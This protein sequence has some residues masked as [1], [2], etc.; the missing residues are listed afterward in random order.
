MSKKETTQTPRIRRVTYISCFTIEMTEDGQIYSVD[1][2]ADDENHAI[3][4]A[5]GVFPN[6]HDFKLSNIMSV[7]GVY[8]DVD[9]IIDMVNASARKSNQ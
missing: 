9:S 5:Q 6:A 2:A 7:D 4:I 1:I 8:V 3:A